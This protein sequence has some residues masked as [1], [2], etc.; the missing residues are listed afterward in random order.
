[1]TSPIKAVN[2]CPRKLLVAYFDAAWMTPF[3]LPLADMTPIS[4]P[5][6]MVNIKIAV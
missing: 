3:K 4:P 6:A 5:K 2:S 1:M